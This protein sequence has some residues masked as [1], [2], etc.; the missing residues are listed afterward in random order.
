MRS[1]SLRARL[2]LGVVALAAA[3][4]TAADVVTYASLQSFLI[5]RTD[6]FLNTAHV[7]AE[8][9]LHG[10]GASGGTQRSPSADAPHAEQLEATV[11]GLFVQVRRPN[12][13]IVATGAAPQFS[14]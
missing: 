8:G 9:A 6:D 4:L 3:G 1:L 7:S 12:G 14:G 5:S 13:T 10:R 2:I 11:P